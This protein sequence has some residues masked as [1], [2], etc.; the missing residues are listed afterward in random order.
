MP[1]VASIVL[2]SDD[3]VHTTAFYRALGMDF[4]DEVHGDGLLHATTDVGDVHVAVFPGSGRV[5]PPSSAPGWSNGG[6]T[7]VGF[8]VPSLDEAVASIRAL[9]S[10][11]LVE[12]QACEWGCRVIAEDPDARAV[13]INQRG[14]CGGSAEP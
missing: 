4:E 8:Y 2:F 3:P 12:H 6:S 9:G 5:G 13:E 14:H 1:E 7:F 11:L 10:K